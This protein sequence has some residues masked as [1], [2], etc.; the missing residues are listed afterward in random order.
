MFAPMDWI[1]FSTYCLP[2]KPMVTTT[3]SDEV[4]MTMPSA[5]ST[6]R[7]LLVLKESMAMLTTSLKS[8]VL[9]AVSTSGVVIVSFYG[10]QVASGVSLPVT[11]PA[12]RNLVIG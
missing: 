3:I 12:K 8:I 6:N 7:T 2:V 1:R 11:Y 9:R 10:I 4:P 5:V